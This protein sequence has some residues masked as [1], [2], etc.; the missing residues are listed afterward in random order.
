ML[1][2]IAPG[3]AVFEPEEVDVLAAACGLALRKIDGTGL[4]GPD[5]R[6]D[7]AKLVHNLGRSRLRHR[8]R[9]RDAADAATLAEE[10]T[11]LLGYLRQAPEIALTS[12]GAPP[13]ARAV[14]F[15]PAELRAPPTTLLK[16]RAVEPIAAMAAKRKRTRVNAGR[17]GTKPKA[18]G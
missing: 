9:L 1:D 14:P 7:V 8:K 10:A 2:A 16:P 11:D 12:E 6:E 3:A 17:P 18:Q 5:V 4:D 15:F 13:M